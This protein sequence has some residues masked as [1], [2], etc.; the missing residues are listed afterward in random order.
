MGAAHGRAMDGTGRG[1]WTPWADKVRWRQSMAASHLP[2]VLH[3]DHR[4]SNIPRGPPPLGG[5]IRSQRGN[6]GDIELQLKYLSSKEAAL[7]RLGCPHGDAGRQP[8]DMLDIIQWKF[9]WT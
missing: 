3:H 4:T 5:Y 6:N 7:P 2:P 8:E 1:P 9:S